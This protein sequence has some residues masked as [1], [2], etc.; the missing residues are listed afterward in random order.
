MS[1]LAEDA[2]VTLVVQW[3]TANRPANIPASVPVLGAARDELRTRPCVVLETS[4]ARSVSAMAST[5]R[6]K[7]DV[8]LF[9]QT[10]DTPAATHATIAAALESLLGD[11]DA[12]IADTGSP[13]F[14]LHALIQRETSTVPDE[15]SGRETVLS[16]EAVVTAG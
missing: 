16:F 8:H 5:F 12:I 1:Q 13:G 7:L 10:D 4:E 2:L 11:S 6:M 3:I 9:S 15:T 14:L